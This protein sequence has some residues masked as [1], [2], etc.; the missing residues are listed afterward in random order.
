[1]GFLGKTSPNSSFQARIGQ[2]HPSCSSPDPPTSYSRAQTGS[3]RALFC[4][5]TRQPEAHR[6][7]PQISLWRWTSRTCEEAQHE[8]GR[9]GRGGRRIDARLLLCKFIM[10]LLKC[11]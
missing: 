8:E 2:I 1:M 5:T 6:L 10:N 9:K 7:C 3:Q 11:E 4:C